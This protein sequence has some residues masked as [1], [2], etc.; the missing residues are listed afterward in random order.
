MAREPRAAIIGDESGPQGQFPLKM[1]G[2]VVKG[3]G[4]GS[5]EVCSTNTLRSYG[6]QMRLNQPISN[7]RHLDGH[8]QLRG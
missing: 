3:F 5:K 2:P 7:F 6:A 8:R 4:R 1:K